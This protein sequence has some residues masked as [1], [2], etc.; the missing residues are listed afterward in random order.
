MNKIIVLLLSAGIGFISF[1]SCKKEVIEVSTNYMPLS[2]GNYWIYQTYVQD[3]NNE[4]NPLTNKMDS[5]YIDKDTLIAGDVY[6]KKITANGTSGQLLTEYIRYVNDELV[7]VNGMV[8]FSANLMLTPS[9]P[10]TT[11]YNIGNYFSSIYTIDLNEQPVTVGGGIF[12]CVD[13]HR[14]TCVWNDNGITTPRSDIQNYYA[15]GIGFVQTL[16]Y[17]LSGSSVRIELERYHIN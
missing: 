12:D 3:A 8:L 11:I 5:V 7:D 9:L 15:E 16:S 6:Y 4:W 2:I 14:G 13:W 1:S 17:L 10:D